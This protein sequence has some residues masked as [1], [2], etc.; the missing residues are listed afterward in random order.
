MKDDELVSALKARLLQQIQNAQIFGSGA[1]TNN[2]YSNSVGPASVSEALSTRS[3][4]SD[5]TPE[6]LNYLV[7]IQKR[8]VKEQVGVDKNGN[9]IYKVVG[10]NKD[11]KRYTEPN[12]YDERRKNKSKMKHKIEKNV[13]LKDSLFGGD[14]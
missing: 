9:P 8:D 11:V 5:I 7:N 10:W 3:S 14:Y 6:E 13:P 4:E 1:L 2:I 12:E